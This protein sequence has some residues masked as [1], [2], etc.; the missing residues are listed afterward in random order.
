MTNCHKT[1]RSILRREKWAKLSLLLPSDDNGE[2]PDGSAFSINARRRKCNFARFSL[3]SAARCHCQYLLLI[4][5]YLWY[6]RLK[7]IST[8]FCDVVFVKS[9]L[10][11]KLSDKIV[12]VNF[13]KRSAALDL[14]GQ[15]QQGI[16]LMLVEVANIS[17]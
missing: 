2:K 3:F 17:N 13:L 4:L 1:Q 14:E 7:K 16:G 9:R 5:W 6:L 15:K 8:L 12:F 10:G 11:A